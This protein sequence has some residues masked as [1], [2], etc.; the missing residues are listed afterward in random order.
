M[1]MHSRT[2]MTRFSFL[3]FNLSLIMAAAAQESL[4]ESR[5]YAVVFDA[6]STGSRVHVYS[7][8]DNME[9]IPINGVDI[10]FA[11]K[12]KPGLSA[13]ADNPEEA[14]NSLKEILQSAVEAVPADARAVTPVRLGA[15]AGLRQISDVKAD[16]ILEA[17]RTLISSTTPFKF[18]KGWV[19]ILDGSQEGSF[20]WITIN[21]LLS[22]LG[23]SYPNTVGIVDLGGGSV[24]MTYAIS[25]EQ[26]KKAPKPEGDDASYITKMSLNGMN[27]HLY[28]H[29]YL[30]YGLLAARAKILNITLDKASPCIL[31]GYNGTYVYDGITYSSLALSSGASFAKCRKVVKKALRIDQVCN[32][33][34]CTFSGVW[35]GGGGDGQKDLFLTSYFYDKANQVGLIGKNIPNA[36]VSLRELGKAAQMACKISYKDATEKYPNVWVD[37]L[38]YV[39]MDLLYQYSL[40]VDGF[41]IKYQR[42]V[43]LVEGLKYKD[44]TVDASW[45]IGGAIDLIISSIKSMALAY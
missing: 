4:Y 17:V 8:G 1:A 5:R 31:K 19:S 44:Y 30:N 12:V 38:P 40:L 21:Y 7:F 10:E 41:G 39:C 9:L 20:M 25:E 6:G 43:T 45:A 13:Y 29:S 36:K 15:T 26:S 42:K 23:K 14:A 24:Q 3:L 22:N 34:K 33:E 11:K 28:V 2:A 27:Y 18:E 37:S 16:K 32:Y 35:N